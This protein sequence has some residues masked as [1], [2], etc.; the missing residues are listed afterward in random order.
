MDVMFDLRGVGSVVL[1]DPSLVQVD[2]V[3]TDFLF[4]AG[5][6]PAM[7][8][9]LVE[10]C[11]ADLD[12]GVR[13]RCT[14]G[15]LTPVEVQVEEVEH[16]QQFFFR[17]ASGEVFVDAGNEIEEILGTAQDVLSHMYNPQTHDDPPSSRI[18]RGFLAHFL[19]P[20]GRYCVTVHYILYELDEVGSPELPNVVLRFTRVGA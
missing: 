18:Y 1:Y 8:E 7:P 10:F 19:I 16:Q 11:L 15:T 6:P 4:E 20:P 9:G 14:T 13:F 5:L 2:V 12:G 3:H 17:T